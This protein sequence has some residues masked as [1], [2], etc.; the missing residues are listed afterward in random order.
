[1]G[2]LR[3]LA[4]ALGL[5]LCGGFAAAE[6][7]DLEAE[8]FFVGGVTAYELPDLVAFARAW[9]LAADGVVTVDRAAAAIE[10]LYRED[11]YLLAEVEIRK[12][13]PGKPAVLHVDEGRI[14]ALELVGVEDSALYALI[15][16]YFRP[17]L[18]EAPL[19][20]P[21]L[22]RAL[23]LTDDLAGVDAEIEIARIEGAFGRKLTVRV[24]RTPD[25]LTLTLD[26][27]PRTADPAASA[28]L[29]GAASSLILPG[30]LLRA[31]IGATQLFGDVGDDFTLLGFGA[32]RAPV[33][34]DGAFVE[35]LVGNSYGESGGG[36]GFVATDFRGLTVAGAAG[37]PLLRNI[38]EY[39]YLI[40]E[41]RFVDARSDGVGIDEESATVAGVVSLVY[42]RVFESD[43]SGEISLSLTGGAR[44]SGGPANGDD[45]FWHLRANAALVQPLDLLDD[46]TAISFAIA[47]QATGSDLPPI[48]TFYLGDRAIL[49]GFDFAEAS[50][51]VGVSASVEISRL[52]LFD[53]PVRSVEPSIFADIGWTRFNSGRPG[54]DRE[55]TL[56]SFG[57]ALKASLGANAFLSGWLAAPF[58]G[59]PAT[60][61]LDP[62][63]FVS[64]SYTW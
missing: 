3:A 4:A 15:S 13:G 11:G 28:Y 46:Q 5:S 10:V 1:M 23:M 43:G 50:G 63:V 40:G 52:M 35:A 34:E 26:N 49:R 59:G 30:D 39:G 22:E 8:F 9:T 42:G 32:Y 64:F 16:G 12:Y 38:A 33:G 41:A 57:L 21:T 54:I 60:D 44:V 61:A 36:G 47:G 45:A 55:E 53:G 14:E 25:T 24:R 48:E 27:W 58:E 6:R 7:P 62:S 19:T 37:W 20:W 29:S 56:G 17:V 31:Q 2:L 18:T 51:D